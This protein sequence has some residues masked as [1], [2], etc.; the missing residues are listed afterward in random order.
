[1]SGT[2]GT[3]RNLA[4]SSSNWP[5]IFSLTTP[6]SRNNETQTGKNAS[7]A[8][9]EAPKFNLPKTAPRHRG[10]HEV[11]VDHVARHRRHEARVD[12]HAALQVEAL[13]AVEDLRVAARGLRR[14]FD[15]HRVAM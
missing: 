15:S 2:G 13:D 5:L 14:S 7:G 4:F 3:G 1:M 12:A 10:G 9:F 8:H 11:Q 6:E